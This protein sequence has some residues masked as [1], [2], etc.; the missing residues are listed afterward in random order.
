MGALSDLP[1]ELISSIVDYLYDDRDALGACALVSRGFVARSQAHL[2][3]HLGLRKG[4]CAFDYERNSQGDIDAMRR[5]I[6]SDPD[7]PLSYTRNL[8]IFP[9]S[10]TQPQDLEEIYDHWTT[11]KNVRELQVHLFAAHFV[12]GPL[13]LSR[14]LSHFQPTL[15]RLHLQT[16]L[17]NPKDL[18]TFITF[19]PLLEDVSIETLSLDLPSFPDNRSEG[20][21]PEL[22]PPLGGSLLLRGSRDENNFLM[23]LAKVRIRYH[24]LSICEPMVWM[25]LQELVIACAPTLRVLKI[26]REI[27]E[28]FPLRFRAPLDYRITS[29]GSRHV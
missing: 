19:F 6:S 18:I 3:E 1:A 25:G 17:E 2:F 10:L 23:E 12:Q 28:F 14:Y 29:L 24:T 4:R 20:F 11:F 22:F 13:F 16:S 21:R 8:S 7:G 5:Y 15:R 27:C 9:G 26:T